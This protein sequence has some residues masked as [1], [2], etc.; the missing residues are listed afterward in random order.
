MKRYLQR[1]GGVAPGS[2]TSRRMLPRPQAAMRCVRTISRPHIGSTRKKCHRRGRRRDERPFHHLTEV[3]PWS[4]KC[5]MVE[6]AGYQGPDLGE[7]INLQEP[8]NSQVNAEPDEAQYSASQQNNV[9]VH[10]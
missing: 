2:R 4:Q 6:F 8:S 5:R 3:R 7:L 10:S 1:L 9:E